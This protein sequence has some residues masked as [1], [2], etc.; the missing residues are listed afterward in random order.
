MPIILAI[1]GGITVIMLLSVLMYN[2]FFRMIHNAVKSAILA[3]HDEIQ[4]R[5]KPE[6]SESLDNV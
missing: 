3:A 5:P 2:L 4:S 1:V 6:N